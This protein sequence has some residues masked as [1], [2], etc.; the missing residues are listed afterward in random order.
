MQSYQQSRD[1]NYKW[2]GLARNDFNT[3]HQR[4]IIIGSFTFLPLKFFALASFLAGG[5][6]FAI[7]ICWL[8]DG[9]TKDKVVKI[10][11][12]YFNNYGKLM[13]NLALRIKD[14]CPKLEDQKIKAP[15]IISNHS[16]W[17]DT[18]YIA[19][20]YSPVSFVAKHD[21]QYWPIIGPLSKAINCIF[22]KRESENDR[23]S[24]REL[25]K[26]RIDDFYTG[27]SHAF[28][29]V[30]YPEGTTS[31]NRVILNFKSGAF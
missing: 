18:F 5:L 10:C 3:W 28:P 16:C 7:I 24:V 22:V 1:Q 27:K 15:I 31:N 2:E 9:P 14:S 20:K 29:L 11:M 13:N 26:Q 25:I 6:I 4:D 23:N 21:I 12:W 19:L 17:F 30:I 8:K